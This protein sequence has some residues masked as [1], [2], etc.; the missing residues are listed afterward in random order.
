MK[1][2]L[3]LLF[4]AIGLSA[5]GQS[6]KTSSGAAGQGTSAQVDTAGQANPAPPV[7]KY[8]PP[9]VH[10]NTL[11]QEPDDLRQEIDWDS[12]AASKIPA[13]PVF[14]HDFFAPVVEPF[15]RTT[16]WMSQTARLK[17][18]AT[19]TFVSQY[20][21][22]TPARVRHAETDGR[23]D[24]TAAWKVYD[25]WSTSGSIS[26]VV[27][28]QVNIG[29][30]Q[31]YNL[32]SSLGSGLTLNCLQ[33]GGAEQPITLNLLYWRQDILHKRLSFYIGKIHPNEF[34]SLSMFN[35]DERTQFLN[36][37]S[38]GNASF[39]SDGAYAGG[40]AVEWQATPRLYVHALTVDTEGTP[41]GNLKTM[42]DRKYMQSVELGWFSGEPGKRY[43][44]YRANFWR[45]DTSSLGSGAGG[46]IGFEHEHRSGWTTFGR[47]GFATHGG[48]SIRQVE[49]L[50]LTQMKPFG[51][52]GDMFGIALVHS[53]PNTA[54]HHH[55]SLLESF[56]RLRL[57]KS[58]D[59]GPDVEV[60]LHPTN[61]SRAYTPTLLGLR[62]RIIL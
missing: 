40:A 9:S 22:G 41:Q 2:G 11:T 42:V 62:M 57:T 61:A 37:A 48:S 30:S 10:Y 20:A 5:N 23:A 7:D 12:V 33:G 6:A 1:I 46:G 14:T 54:A 44:N 25:S 26:M 60:V 15:N 27:R 28:S 18:G 38:D 24:V 52:R 29:I 35:D 56:Y 59:I 43:R 50:G 31:Q 17:F 39:A 45:D 51:R 3:L 21:T 16:D 49:E 58:V 36:G 4:V 55:E 19:Y 13:D 34:I 32:S 53:E 8:T 47:L